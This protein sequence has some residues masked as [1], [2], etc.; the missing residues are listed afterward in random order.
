MVLQAAPWEC[1]Y[2]TG[3]QTLCGVKEAQLGKSPSQTAIQD[4]TYK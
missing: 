3:T 1:Q 2:V 4:E